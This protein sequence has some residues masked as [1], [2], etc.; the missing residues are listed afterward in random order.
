[1][2]RSSCSL[3]AGYTSFFPSLHKFITFV[4]VGRCPGVAAIFLLGVAGDVHLN[5]KKIYALLLG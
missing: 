3:E 2:K 1:M 4:G 5:D